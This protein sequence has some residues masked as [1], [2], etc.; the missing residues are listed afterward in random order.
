METGKD[1]QVEGNIFISYSHKDVEIVKRIAEIIKDSCNQN[2]WYDDSLRG[3]DNYFGAIADQ[4]M[5]SNFFVF[6]VSDNSVTSNWCLRELEYAVS[7][8]KIIVPIWLDDI[9]IPPRVELSIQNTHYIY[10]HQISQEEFFVEIRKV[11]SGDNVGEEGNPDLYVGMLM[12]A[13]K[14]GS[15]EAQR[16]LAICYSVGLD[17]FQMDEAK[18]VEL[19]A[20]A[21]ERGDDFSQYEL[22]TYYMEGK[23]VPKNEKTAVDL[24]TKSAEQGYHRAQYELGICYLNGK[25]VTKNEAKAINWLTMAGKQGHPQAQKNL[26]ICY[27]EGRGVPKDESKAVDWLTKAAES[28]EEVWV[29][30]LD[31]YYR[32][33]VTLISAKLDKYTIVKSSV[34]G[35]VEEIYCQN[36]QKIQAGDI[37]IK[38]KGLNTTTEDIHSSIS[39]IEIVA[40]VSG[41][42]E[43]VAAYRH[44]IITARTPLIVISNLNEP[45]DMDQSKVADDDTITLKAASCSGE[46]RS[47]DDNPFKEI[48]AIFKK[49]EQSAPKYHKKDET[50]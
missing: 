44:R 46:E 5:L 24:F 12:F 14:L 26:G 11:F 21:A 6:I 48:F 42:I 17:G 30:E 31:Q 45:T 8:E 28:E 27:L 23:V 7:K 29:P 43:F 37:L 35:K 34:R 49:G 15:T 47:L 22:G 18:A 50:V 3:G 16:Q 9:S 2:I 10:Y 38:A 19:F 39:E 25:G 4:I 13:A 33:K 20:A 32:R 41:V 40:P 1:N 36:G